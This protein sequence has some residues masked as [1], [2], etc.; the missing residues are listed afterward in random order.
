M[1]QHL[2]KIKPL[3]DLPESNP[4]RQVIDQAVHCPKCDMLICYPTEHDAK[5][6]YKFCPRCGISIYWIENA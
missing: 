4:K 2:A 3:Y 5:K 1:K 6:N